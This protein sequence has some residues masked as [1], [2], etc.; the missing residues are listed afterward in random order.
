MVRVRKKSFL[1]GTL[2]TPILMIA[3]IVLPVIFSEMESDKVKKYDIVDFTG[4]IF[5]E[6]N[7][8]VISENNFYDLREI[9][10]KNRNFDEIKTGLN[11]SVLD[12]KI[13]AYIIIPEDIYEKNSFEYYAKSSTNFSEFR[14]LEG[15]ISNI[16]NRQRLTKEGYDPEVIDKV[17]KDV[18][19]VPIKVTKSGEKVERGQTFI[20][21]YALVMILYI[22][23]LMYGVVVMRGIIEEKSSRIVEII[24]SSVRPF[25]LMTAKLLGVGAVGLTQVIIYMGVGIFLALNRANIISL[26]SSDPS[27]DIPDFFNIPTSIFIYFGIFYFLGYFLFSV[28]YA[29]IGAM[30]NTEEEAQNIQ[31]PVIMLLIIPILF[32]IQIIKT[33]DSTLSVVLSL[34]PFFSP[35]LMFA[36]IC[37]SAPPFLEIFLSIFLMIGTLLILLWVTGKIYRVGIL[38]YGKRPTIAE[39]IKWIKY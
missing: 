8:Y 34:I 29:A 21:T 1:I 36:R 22:S 38:M 32:M 23:V 3:F 15:Y 37:V 13:D 18:N 14:Q 26:I 16:V 9:N 33:P 39:V 25:Q 11:K 27:G 12:K 35:L 10:I 6:L 31:F 30:V 17:Y 19:L 7:E 2:I 5:K 28:I 20:I 4:E 24:V